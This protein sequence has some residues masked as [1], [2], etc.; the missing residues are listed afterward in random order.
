MRVNDEFATLTIETACSEYGAKRFLWGMTDIALGPT[1]LVNNYDA[2]RVRPCHY[3]GLP[4]YAYEDIH[5]MRA[6][7]SCRRAR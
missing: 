5:L 1:I 6:I 2:E 4:I 7:I 3:R